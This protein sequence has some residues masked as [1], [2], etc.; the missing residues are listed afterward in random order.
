MARTEP[1][2]FEPTAE[3]HRDIA[4]QSE[5][6][7]KK[8]DAMIAATREFKVEKDKLIEMM[9]NAGLEAYHD[10]EGHF[11]VVLSEKTNVKVKHDGD[12]EE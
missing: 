10:Q 1:L 3:S 12:D 9:R 7:E 5:L 8:R 4:K 2:P 11:T 6:Y